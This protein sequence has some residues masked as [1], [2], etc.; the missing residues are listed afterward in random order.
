MCEFWDTLCRF[1]DGGD[2]MDISNDGLHILDEM[3]F[4]FNRTDTQRTSRI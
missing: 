4:Q 3:K 2:K 1:C